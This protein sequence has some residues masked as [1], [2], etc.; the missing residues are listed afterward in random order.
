MK[1]TKYIISNG[2]Y[3]KFTGKY[4]HTYKCLGCGDIHEISNSL[5]TWHSSGYCNRTYWS[6][7]INHSI[8]RPVSFRFYKNKK[9]EKAVSIVAFCNKHKEL[10]E[11][12]KYHFSEVI[13]GK[14]LHYKGWLMADNKIVLDLKKVKTIEQ[15]LLKQAAVNLNHFS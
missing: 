6:N 13:N 8:L 2:K 14:R 11:N 7:N 10:G 12:A 1:D 9:P 3:N 4:S 5:K 15:T